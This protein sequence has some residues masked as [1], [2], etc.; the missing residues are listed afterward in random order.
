MPG[1]TSQILRADHRHDQIDEQRQGD[2]AAQHIG[3]GHFLRSSAAQPA[4]KASVSSKNTARTVKN[5]ISTA[6]PSSTQ[7]STK[8]RDGGTIGAPVEKRGSICHRRCKGG[9]NRSREALH[10]GTVILT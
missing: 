2:D 8:R 1:R 7:C 3:P 9:V 10:F 5:R 6:S 4:T